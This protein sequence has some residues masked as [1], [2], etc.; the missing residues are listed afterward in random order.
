MAAVT[1]DGMRLTRSGGERVQVM[2]WT[3]DQQYYP[4]LSASNY[5]SKGC[6]TSPYGKINFR[7]NIL[8]FMISKSKL[9]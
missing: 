7:I 5:T 6:N 3:L 4:G 2:Y 1:E 8:K 9:K